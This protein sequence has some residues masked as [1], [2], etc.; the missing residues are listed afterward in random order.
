MPDHAHMMISIPSKYAV[1]EAVG[2]I[3]G[4]NAIHPARV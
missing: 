2:F 4:K 3:K 1:S